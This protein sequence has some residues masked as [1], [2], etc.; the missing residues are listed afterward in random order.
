MTPFVMIWM[1]LAQAH[2]PAIYFVGPDDDWCA[3][4][5]SGL[6]GDAFKFAPGDYYGPCAIDGLPPDEYGEQLYLESLDPETPAMFHYGGGDYILSV[7]GETVRMGHLALGN[8]PEGIPAIRIAGFGHQI[9]ALTATALVGPAIQFAGDSILVDIVDVEL[10][11]T[12]AVVIEV[13]CVDCVTGDPVLRNNLIVGADVGIHATET[14]AG[15]VLRNVVSSGQTAL[16]WHAQDVNAEIEG[17]LLLADDTALVVR[18]G[19]V[20]VHSNIVVGNPALWVPEG[21]VSQRII[22]NTLVAG[23]GDGALLENGVGSDGAFLNNALTG[24]ASGPGEFAGNVDCSDAASCWVDADQRD[25]YATVASPLRSDGVD[26]SAEDERLDWC[27]R[28]RAEV[29]TVGALEAVSQVG[30]GAIPLIAQEYVDCDVPADPK[31]TDTTTDPT[32]T[33]IPPKE[34]GCGCSATTAGPGWLVLMALL[35]LI[36]RED[37]TSRS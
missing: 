10:V 4:V 28:D 27:T 11:S 8:V 34:T 3:E 5:A 12:G 16:D 7:T 26:V 13:G 15:V 35:G 6:T 24:E 18:Q 17:N 31:T 1:A 36:R 14:T 33:D 30:F 20:A 22:G 21:A 9:K 23:Q 2:T 29:P 32:P 37:A 19:P 25:F